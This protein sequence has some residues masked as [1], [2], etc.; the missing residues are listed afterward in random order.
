M[1]NQ[2]KWQNSKEWK[3]RVRLWK[4]LYRNFKEQLEEANMKEEH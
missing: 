4:S 3:K 1:K 2:L